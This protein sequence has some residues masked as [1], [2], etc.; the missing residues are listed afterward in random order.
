M[1]PDDKELIVRSLVDSDTAA[2]D[3]LVRRYQSRVRGWLRHL[4]G[5]VAIAD[6]IAQETFLRAWRKL[7]TYK[8]S[9]S[10]NAW[11]LTI[12]RNEF[13]Q[14]RRKS[15]RE[16]KRRQ[17][18]IGDGIPGSGQAHS[19]LD[20][21]SHDIDRFLDVLKRDERDTMILVYGFGLSHSEASEVSG[22]PLGSVK[23]HLRRGVSK[24]REQF[25]LKVPEHD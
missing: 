11:L 1:A 24:I 4:T 6:D 9:G 21:E 17:E 13:L 25:G 12:A 10:F 8:A 7:G 3:E 16:E 5:D 18:L 15:G 14:Y 19:S 20:E 2:F 22:L 23:S